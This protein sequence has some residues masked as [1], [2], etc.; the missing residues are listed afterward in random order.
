M[1]KDIIL[2][3]GNRIK[4]KRT[5]KRITLEKLADE[6]GVTKGLISQIENNR[7]VPSLPVLFSI[8]RG[9]GIDLNEFFDQLYLRGEE[10]AI[11]IRA[12]QHEPVEKEYKQG[13]YYNRILSFRQN[14]KLIDV[15]LYRQE[16][17]AERGFVS[18]NA[19]EF[20]YMLEG[21]AQYTI[22]ETRYVLEKG[23]S[24]YF[25]AS[26]PHLSECLSEDAYTML[27]IYFFEN[28]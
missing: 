24:F 1:Q 4:E 9:L 3:I 25:D 27:V 14:G 19:Q 28:G 6:I 15:V 8:I 7:T 13:S 5:G 21:R 2:Q 10:D 18:T 17:G 11:L 26:K 22:G 16:R 20:N 12:G 23:D